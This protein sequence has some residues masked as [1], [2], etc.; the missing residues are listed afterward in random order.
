VP[1]ALHDGG[2]RIAL[3]NVGTGYSSLYQLRNF[4][5]DKIKIDR[6]FIHT[7]SSD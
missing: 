2:V 4:K 7:M 5:L 3:D 1:G 6:S